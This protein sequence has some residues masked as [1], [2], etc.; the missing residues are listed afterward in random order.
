[1]SQPTQN[2]STIQVEP[3]HESSARQQIINAIKER[4]KFT[5]CCLW[6]LFLLAL[7]SNTT[8]NY[9]QFIGPF[10]NKVQQN[11][12]CVPPSLDVKNF[13]DLEIKFLTQSDIDDSCFVYDL[14]YE[15]LSAVVDNAIYNNTD[16]DVKSCIEIGGK[17]RFSVE[18]GQSLSADFGIACE[19]EDILS[20]FAEAIYVGLIIGGAFIGIAGD[21]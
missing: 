10:I 8:F 7:L 21:V 15:N 9:F 17:F 1:M 14:P 5:S 19:N 6:K 3:H 11:F 13:S 16:I 20:D 4:S 12:T 2:S 18:K